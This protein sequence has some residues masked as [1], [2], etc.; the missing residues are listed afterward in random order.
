MGILLEDEGYVIKSILKADETWAVVKSF[1]PS[2]ILLDVLLSGVDGKAIC[3]RLKQDESTKN[4]PVLML[5]AHAATE[6][7]FD[8]CGAEAFIAKPFKTEDLLLTIEL[9]T[10]QATIH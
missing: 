3:T 7:S 8:R 10:R 9:L 1:K 4:I 6:A 5:S 2:I